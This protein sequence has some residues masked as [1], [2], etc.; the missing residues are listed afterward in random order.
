MCLPRTPNLWLGGG[1][2]LLSFCRGLEGGNNTPKEP[3]RGRGVI[4]PQRPKNKVQDFWLA[5]WRFVFGCSFSF[6][7]FFWGVLGAQA[8]APTSELRRVCMS[9]VVKATRTLKSIVSC[10]ASAHLLSCCCYYEF[11]F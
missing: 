4:P 8:Y 2:R 6:F 10:F 11:F 9:L 7:S 1:L 5:G 3:D